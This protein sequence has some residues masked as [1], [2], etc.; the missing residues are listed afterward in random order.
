MKD[1][2]S[3][4]DEKKFQK[5][6]LFHNFLKSDIKNTD[7]TIFQEISSVK[8]PPVV[9]HCQDWEVF[10]LPQEYLPLVY[11]LDKVIRART[12]RRD[13]TGQALTL[14]ELSTLLHYS[15]GIRRRVSAYNTKEFPLRMVPTSG[16]L[17]GVELY[18]VTNKVEGL[19]KGIY[20]FN[21]LGPAL[22]LMDQG[23]FRRKLVNYCAYQ[24][25]V[26]HASVVVI[27]SCAINR[28]LWKYGPRAYRYIHM[29][30]GFVG[31][32]LYLVGTALKLG[33]CA[34]AG[35]F[36]DPLNEMI[37]ARDGEF[38]SLLIAVGKRS[39]GTKDAR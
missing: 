23:N 38:V 18:V 28:L 8:A 21:P 12:S 19:E 7:F 36:D 11:S 27:L 2:I 3:T 5:L 6:T 30:V 39:S 4:S 22:E 16:G 17:Q 1:T 31:Q 25:F 14:Q 13:Y 37:E 15:Y 9:R 10:P 32:N 24:E 26:G 35:F 29:D 20:H 34:I 33:V